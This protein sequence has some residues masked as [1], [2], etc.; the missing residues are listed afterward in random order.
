MDG[1]ENGS[2]FDRVVLGMIWHFLLNYRGGRGEGGGWLW[3]E[4]VGRA[5]WSRWDS[6]SLTSFTLIGI[7]FVSINS[8]RWSAGNEP[9]PT[10][11]RFLLSLRI[12]NVYICC[13]RIG[14]SL[15]LDRQSV[16]VKDNSDQAKTEAE[17]DIFFDVCRLFPSATV[18]AER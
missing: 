8:R 9:P 12:K 1:I 5:V 10:H 11:L 16:S 15:L 7:D 17:A 14:S 3:E 13:F 2:E 4:G 18:V 6:S